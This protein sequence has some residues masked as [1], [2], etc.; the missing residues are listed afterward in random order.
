MGGDHIVEGADVV[1]V[2]MGDQHPS[3]HGR[4][5]PGTGEAH[6]HSPTGVDQDVGVA[7]L[8]QGRRPRSIGVGQR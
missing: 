8:D 4:H 6:H 1:A 5:H 2:Q 3:E 7:G